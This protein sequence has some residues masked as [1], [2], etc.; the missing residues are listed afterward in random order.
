MFASAAGAA[1]WNL[2]EMSAKAVARGGAYAEP[3]DA[4]A[5]FYNPA[6]LSMLTGTVV[7]VGMTMLVP[8]LDTE[9]NGH[10]SSRMDSG[11]F[12]VPNVFVS[13]EL[14]WDFTFGLGV[15][16]DGG[17]G[18]EYDDYWPLSWETV[19]ADFESYTVNPNLSYRI[20]EDWSIAAGMRCVHTAF[21]QKRQVPIPGYGYSHVELD[22]DN[23]VDL[24]WNVGT[25]YRVLDNLSVGFSY[26]S[27][28]RCD[29]EGSSKATGPLAPGYTAPDIGDKLNMPM[30]AT[31][32]FNWD[33]TEPLH[34]SGS[35][36]WTDWSQVDQ[37][38]FKLPSGVQT[39]DLGWNDTWRLGCGLAY[40]FTD[41]FTG[42]FSYT[43][44]RCPT[45][46]D[47]PHVMLPK[48]DRHILSTGVSYEIW[49]FELSLAY[50]LILLENETVHFTDMYG[51]GYDFKS[52]NYITQCA[53]FTVTYRF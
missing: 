41:A 34:F 31:L 35:A 33:I 17:L 16:A 28:V 12:F 44:D 29:L 2:Y 36:T 6:G 5:N 15:Y 37:L 32:G 9:V 7:T 50:M 4:S 20:T 19:T 3:V 11:Y 10:A 53:C 45:D 21:N 42:A 30:S 1:G 48:G 46:S 13:Q 52:A 49:R 26:R 8:R 23:G 22:A 39:L 24:G 40:D 14:P 51:R 43:Y 38:H 27:E 18:A 25:L 47:K